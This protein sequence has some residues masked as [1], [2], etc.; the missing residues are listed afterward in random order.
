MKDLHAVSVEIAIICFL[1]C[2][3]DSG[4]WR[5]NLKKVSYSLR[6]FVHFYLAVCGVH[7]EDPSDKASSL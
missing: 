3:G 4:C 1:N 7:S 2:Y 5:L 6:I